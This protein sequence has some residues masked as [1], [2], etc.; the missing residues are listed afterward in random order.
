MGYNLT[1]RMEV[2]EFGVKRELSD[3]RVTQNDAEEL[4]A[5]L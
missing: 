3:V 4:Q 1:G 5:P 2:K